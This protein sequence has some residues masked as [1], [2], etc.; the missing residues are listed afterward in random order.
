MIAVDAACV[1]VAL[2][3]AGHVH[4][5]ERSLRMLV[6]WAQDHGLAWTIAQVDD[7]P[8]LTFVPTADGATPCRWWLIVAAL[9]DRPFKAVTLRRVQP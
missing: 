7:D 3:R 2:A 9:T 4:V 8:G 5:K 6:R 1:A